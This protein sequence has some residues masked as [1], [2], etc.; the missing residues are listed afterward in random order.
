ML[1]KGRLLGSLSEKLSVYPL[2]PAPRILGEFSK[3]LYLSICS[4]LLLSS[5]IFK[6]K[7]PTV[8]CE[9]RFFVLVLRVLFFW[10]DLRIDFVMSELRINYLEKE[11]SSSFSLLNYINK[12][13][14]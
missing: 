8:V 9:S 5:L 4:F 2:Q 6:T 7:Y 1:R 10:K 13:F 3:E 12:Q 11:G 14:L